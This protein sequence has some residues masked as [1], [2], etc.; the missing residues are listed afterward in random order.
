[1]AVTGQPKDPVR[2]KENEKSKQ[3]EKAAA[4]PDFPALGCCVLVDARHSSRLD[5]IKDLK[6][7]LLFEDILEAKSLND[8]E[9]LL[10]RHR[11]D[12][13]FIGP[14]VSPDRAIEFITA[15]KKKDGLNDCAFIALINM[16]PAVRENLLQNGAHRVIER[17]YS[18][19]LFVKEVINAIIAA[20]EG[21]P[22]KALAVSLGLIQEEE[23]LSAPAINPL[24]AASQPA[25]AGEIPATTDFNKLLSS[26]NLNDLGA[27]G[28]TPSLGTIEKIKG[29]INSLL[30]ERSD[31]ASL[32]ELRMF[33]EGEIQQWITD[34]Q[35]V[36]REMATK[37]LK[38][39]LGLFL[40]NKQ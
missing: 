12:A 16:D 33:L 19:F 10:E 34:Q 30:P 39:K 36:S 37:N 21:H 9:V 29:L 27:A 22:W 8:A 23:N 14:S 1:M 20:N 5:I 24:L 38:R 6:A 4:L 17:P 28:G 35:V 25:A 11:P 31:G 3:Q 7:S 15:G 2:G 18:K 13:C 32:Q 40:Q 26:L